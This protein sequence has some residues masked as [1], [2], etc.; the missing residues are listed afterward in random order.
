MSASDV[1]SLYDVP[2]VSWAATSADLTNTEHYPNFFRVVPPDSST[3]M[4]LAKF[5]FMF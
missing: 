2:H 5:F 1:L 4:A 3:M